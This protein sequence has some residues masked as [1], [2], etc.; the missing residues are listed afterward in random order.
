MSE[1]DAE[2]FLS[3][4]LRKVLSMD[5]AAAVPRLGVSLPIVALV[6]LFGL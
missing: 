5:I 2:V 1:L 6:L 4:A 3:N